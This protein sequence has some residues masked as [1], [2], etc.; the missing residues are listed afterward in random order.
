MHSDPTLIPPRFVSTLSDGHLLQAVRE[1]RRVARMLT[2]YPSPSGQVLREQ[3]RVTIRLLQSEAE[4][5][6]AERP[7]VA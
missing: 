1:Y 3:L 2:R 6:A 4:R 5:R 7:N